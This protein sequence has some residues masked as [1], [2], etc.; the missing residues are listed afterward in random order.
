M[1]CGSFVVASRTSA[2]H[3]AGHHRVQVP[4]LE[5]EQKASFR[6]V[7]LQGHQSVKNDLHRET[8]T[9]KL[10][11]CP[12][13]FRAAQAFTR[14]RTPWSAYLTAMLDGVGFPPGFQL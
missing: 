5:V 11:I 2:V 4:G 14:T 1:S 12:D 13:P 7:S 6:A 8:Q 3:V 10:H 9:F